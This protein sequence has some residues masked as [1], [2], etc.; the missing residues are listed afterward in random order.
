MWSYT[1]FQRAKEYPW[2]VLFLPTLAASPSIVQTDEV[3]G[4][5][6]QRYLDSVRKLRQRGVKR[7]S[8]MK[9]TNSR[10]LSLSWLRSLNPHQVIQK[11]MSRPKMSI[12]HRLRGS[13]IMASCWRSWLEFGITW[14]LCIL[15]YQLPNY[16]HMTKMMWSSFHR[17]PNMQILVRYS[18][19]WCR[20]G[21]INFESCFDL[22]IT[23]CA[24]VE[25][26][27][28]K[29]EWMMSSFR[30]LFR[31]LSSLTRKRNQSQKPIL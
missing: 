9:W 3:D 14:L 20:R 31:V 8:P 30:P 4:V 16:L 25:F 24:K 21:T 2:V 23:W 7:W 12:I 22:L 26:I 29:V 27:N 18:R 11:S 19:E 17:S 1:R 28:S 5:I 15:E 6:V 10:S 13:L